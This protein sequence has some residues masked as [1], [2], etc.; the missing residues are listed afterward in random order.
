MFSLYS[1]GRG[2][3]WNSNMLLDG[4]NVFMFTGFSTPWWTPFPS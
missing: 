2:R 3:F 4:F 1:F